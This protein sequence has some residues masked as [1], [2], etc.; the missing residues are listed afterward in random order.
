MTE[1]KQNSSNEIDLKNPLNFNR[2]GGILLHPTSLPGKYGI[3]ELGPDLYRFIDFLH[4]CGIKLWQILPLGPT[5]YGDSPY[6]CFS[7]FAGNPYVISIEKLLESGLLTSHDM[8]VS[9]PFSHNAIDFGR[10]ID[11]KWQLLHKAYAI[12]SHTSSMSMKEE[13]EKFKSFHAYWLEDYTTFMAIKESQE[14]KLWT[15]WPLELRTREP[16]AL[17]EWKE[18][19]KLE[20]EFQMFVQ[21]LFNMQWNEVKDYTHKQGI[22]IIGDVPIF[23]ALDSADVWAHPNVFYLDE[24]RQPIFV[25]G[26]PP[27][28]FSETGQRWGSPL[29]RWNKLKQDFY[30]WWVKRIQF[31]LDN[32]DIIRIDHFRGF[33]AYWEIPASEPTAVKGHWVKG[34]GKDI[35]KVILN[36]LGVLPII[37]EDLGIITPPVHA[38]R[39]AFNFPGMRILQFAFGDEDSKFTENRFLPHNFEYNTVVYTGTHDNTTS[40]Q[41]FENLEPNIQ[42]RVLEYMNSS[43]K[44]IVGDFIRLAWSSVAK[45]A[46]I[47]L[48]DLLRLGKEARMNFPGKSSGNWTWRFTWDQIKPDYVQE[49]LKLNKLYNR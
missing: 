3:G 4:D 6:L 30:S 7:A 11:F 32:V 18:K 28:F 41:W 46:I 24:E 15:T 22:R 35:F 8:N 37:A 21:F 16:Q 45:M 44:D 29:Y 13:F 38:L 12:F 20:I 27:D 17:S 47:P 2:A 43:G 36:K 10:V 49:L 34:P 42:Q 40:R 5:G 33:E 26:V 48:Q 39:E 19:H 31:T 9:E 14:G 25:A 1:D 23:V